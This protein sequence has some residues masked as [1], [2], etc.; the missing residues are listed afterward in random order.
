[1]STWILSP[2]YSHILAFERSGDGLVRENQIKFVGDGTVGSTPLTARPLLLVEFRTLP[3]CD[4]M[5]RAFLE[6]LGGVSP[7]E[8]QMNV[9]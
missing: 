7:G 6:Q 4:A 8:C 1:M 3:G 2:R 5:G 9:T